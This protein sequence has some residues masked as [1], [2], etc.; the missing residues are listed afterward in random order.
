MRLNIG[1]IFQVKTVFV[2]QVIPVRII[3]IMRVTNV[4]DIGTFHQHHFLFHHLTGDGMAYGRIA[5]VAVHAF[6]LDSLTIYIIVASGQSELVF[7]SGRIFYF[8]FAETDSGGDCF[9]RT[10]FL[11]FQLAY[12]CITVWLFGRPF[13]RVLYFQDCFSIHLQ[14]RRNLGD[15]GGSCYVLYFRIVVRIEFI[16]IQRI[17][18]RI[19]FRHFL[20]QVTDVCPDSQ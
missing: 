12:Q 6:Q 15:G 18:H 2:T 11:I 10:A 20:T 9:Y 19:S 13:I 4:V 7:R 14:A 5:F 17:D 16:G 8:H 3:R 1:F